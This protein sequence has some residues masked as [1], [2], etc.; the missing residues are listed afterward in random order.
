MLDKNVKKNVLLESL[1]IEND[2]DFKSYLNYNIEQALKSIAEEMLHDIEYKLTESGF[3]IVSSK[4]EVK[5]EFGVDKMIECLIKFTS[6]GKKYFLTV[7][8]RYNCTLSM[9]G[10]K[11]VN[12]SNVTEIKDKIKTYEKTHKI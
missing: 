6:K 11:T 10:K 3:E 2:T 7:H 8:N 1:E 12:V 5:K 9:D 4:F